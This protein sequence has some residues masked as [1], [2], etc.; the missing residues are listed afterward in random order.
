MH[1]ILMWQLPSPD[2]RELIGV[3]SDGRHGAAAI[4]ATVLQLPPNT[5][6]E[7]ERFRVNHPEIDSSLVDPFNHPVTP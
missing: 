7:Y 1:S 6:I 5:V 4:A 2:S 3:F